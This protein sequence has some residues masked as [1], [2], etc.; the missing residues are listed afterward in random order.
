MKNWKLST[1]V[2][3]GFA[4]VTL[5]LAGIATIAASDAAKVLESVDSAFTRVDQERFLAERQ[6]DHL[7][8]VKGLSLTLL[9]AGP[10][11]GQLDPAKCKLGLWIY[12]EKEQARQDATTRNVV[13]DME[14]SHKALHHS[15]ERIL[16]RKKAGDEKGAAALLRSESLPA[17]QA[18]GD[19]LEKLR[20]IQNQA[21]TA[22][23]R[24]LMAD[25]RKSRLQVILF[26]CA[27][28][29]VA[30]AVSFLLVR[31]LNQ[32]LRSAVSAL[33]ESSDQAASAARHVASFGESLARDA[34]GEASS[35]EQTSASSEEIQSMA[36]KNR[37]SS[38]AVAQLLLQSGRRFT[39]TSQSLDDTVAAMADIHAQSLRVSQI[40]RTI[41]EIAFQTNILALNAAVEAARAGEAGMGFAVVADAVRELAQRCARAAKDTEDL[42]QGSIRKTDAGKEKVGQVA[43]AMRTL[44][45]DLAHVRTLVDDVNRGSEQQVNG[46]EQIAKAIAS[47]EQVTQRTA[48]NAEESC[49]SAADLTEQ[50]QRLSLIVD[51]LKHMVGEAA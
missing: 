8:W 31:Y 41:D 33:S 36:R 21:A 44:A 3:A 12:D 45:A 9:G 43:A 49:A 48:A 32:R 15:A 19:L 38:A 13:A 37:D 11:Q 27:G 51:D 40:I 24:Q 22:H 17:L 1:R 4:A 26:G 18:T 16:D 50:A 46:I 6:K 42:I 34:T 30:L 28:L 35:I 10:F 25:A 14:R 7:N 5:I 29:L 47:I 20:I 39:E 2:G 23:T